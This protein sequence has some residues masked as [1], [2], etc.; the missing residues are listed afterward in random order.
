MRA[1]HEDRGTESVSIGA[2]NGGTGF[3]DIEG[4]AV[5]DDA[6]GNGVAGDSAGG[7]RGVL[8]PLANGN[9]MYGCNKA[10]AIIRQHCRDKLASITGIKRQ[11]IHRKL[12]PVMLLTLDL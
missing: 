2:G 5:G 3:N 7:G 11:I 1:K 4:G 9:E 8:P 6:A 10:M 12:V